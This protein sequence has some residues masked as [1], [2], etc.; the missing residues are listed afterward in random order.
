[1]GN[2]SGA[3][4]R[5]MSPTW[6]G[7]LWRRDAPAWRGGIRPPTTTRSGARSRMQRRHRGLH[8]TR[9]ESCRGGR[10]AARG[11][12]RGAADQCRDG[13]R[14]VLPGRR[15]G[16]ATRRSPRWNDRRPRTA[17]VDAEA[18]RAA[19]A[20]LREERSEA[21]SRRRRPRVR[22]GPRPAASAPRS[23]R[24]PRHP[25][26]PCGL[27][28]GVERHGGRRS[29]GVPDARAVPRGERSSRSTTPRTR[30]R[31]QGSTTARSWS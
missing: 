16:V 15:T 3:A 13:G 18:V 11:A 27:G 31:R 14:V 26:R 4:S 2:L 8:R 25:T 19:E 10:R 24:G 21:G 6:P 29:P 5:A 23:R 12:R 7:W 22:R 20:L 1:M 9:G 17:A 30:P 28:P